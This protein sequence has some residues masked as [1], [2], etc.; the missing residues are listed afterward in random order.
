MADWYSF[1]NPLWAFKIR[2]HY[3]AAAASKSLQSCLTLCNPI[4]GSPPGSPVPGILQA[5]TLEWVSI[6]FIKLEPRLKS[7][8]SWVKFR[9]IL[10]A[11]KTPK[12][13]GPKQLQIPI[14][15]PD[16]LLTCRA[17]QVVLVV[18]NLPANAGDSRN[19]GPISVLRG[20][21]GV[22]NGNPLQYSC[23]ENF[24]HRRDWRTTVHGAKEN[25]TRLSD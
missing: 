6:S 1:V 8:C 18:K 16:V 20:D 7:Q 10:S 19:V 15:I 13:Q 14:F 24:R 3:A 11:L 4:D 25:R 9:I 21:P 2:N 5:R 17:S 22:G 23:L 12:G